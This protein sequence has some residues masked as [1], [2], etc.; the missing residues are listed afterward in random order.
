[1]TSYRFSTGS[2]IR[3]TREVIYVCFCVSSFSFHFYYFCF[4]VYCY[5]RFLANFVDFVFWYLVLYVY[6]EV[7]IHGFSF[8]LLCSCLFLLLLFSRT[9][10]FIFAL[11]FLFLRSS[12]LV[13]AQTLREN[14][15]VVRAAHS[16]R[17]ASSPPSTAHMEQ[18][19]QGADGEMVRI[20]YD[21]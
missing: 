12:L 1:M 20:G 3:L 5:P 21:I 17:S 10:I 16:L 15:E 18:P 13:D 8:L 6:L 19:F 9:W 14:D 11:V 7:Y 2:Y 4:A